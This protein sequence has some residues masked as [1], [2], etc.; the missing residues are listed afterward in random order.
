MLKG[1]A[2]LIVLLFV[3]CFSSLAFADSKSLDKDTL[4][5][6]DNWTGWLWFKGGT[7]VTIDEKGQL[8]TG[9]LAQ[10]SA[11]WTQGGNTIGQVLFKAGTTVNVNKLGQVITG[12][13]AQDYPF[14]TPPPPYNIGSIMFKGGTSVTFNEKGQLVTGTLAQD[15]MLMNAKGAYQQYKAGSVVSFND[16]GLVY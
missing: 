9:T 6:H 16:R 2:L 14:W 5:F 1:T 3:T 13:L 8:V 7:S 12:T 10:D 15:L 11:F 4:F